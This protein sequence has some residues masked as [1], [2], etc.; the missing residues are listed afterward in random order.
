MTMCDEGYTKGGSVFPRR[1]PR[2]ALT[3][4]G[5]GMEDKSRLNS[6]IEGIWIKDLVLNSWENPS[7]FHFQAT[8][9]ST[10]THLQR[11]EMVFLGRAIVQRKTQDYLLNSVHLKLKHIYQSTCLKKYIHNLYLIL[12]FKGDRGIQWQRTAMPVNFDNQNFPSI[13]KNG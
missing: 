9:R 5:R 1:E 8:D 13:S 4:Q 7:H 11:I 6:T 2:K 12:S 10:I 3:A